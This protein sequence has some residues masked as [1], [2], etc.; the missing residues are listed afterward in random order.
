MGAVSRFAREIQFL[1]ILGLLSTLTTRLVGIDP[2][3]GRTL[4]LVKSRSFYGGD[5]MRLVH[6]RP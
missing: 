5:N 2:G 1:P 4:Y 3:A 6:R